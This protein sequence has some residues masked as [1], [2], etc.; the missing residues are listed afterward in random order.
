MG[1]IGCSWSYRWSVGQIRCFR[2]RGGGGGGWG[3][4]GQGVSFRLHVDK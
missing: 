3:V 4:G 2:V 1:Q